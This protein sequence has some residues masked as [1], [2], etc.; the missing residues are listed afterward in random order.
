MGKI[1]M[2]Q[3][4]YAVLEIFNLGEFSHPK[5][6]YTCIL[7]AKMQ[8][9]SKGWAWTRMAL[10]SF[11][12][13]GRNIPLFGAGCLHMKLNAAGGPRLLTHC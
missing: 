2:R 9:G 7:L 5:W 3:M 4:F 8:K 10:V 11:A 6:E 13:E 12:K 1:L